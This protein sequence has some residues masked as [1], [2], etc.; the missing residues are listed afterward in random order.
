MSSGVPF[1]SAEFRSEDHSCFLQNHQIVFRPDRAAAHLDL[2]GR[3]VLPSLKALELSALDITADEE[4][5]RAGSIAANSEHDGLM[6]LL[7]SAAAGAE[8]GKQEKAVR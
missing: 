6:V 5:R 4:K 3:L 8:E 1:I 7:V 2:W